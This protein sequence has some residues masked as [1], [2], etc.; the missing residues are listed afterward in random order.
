MKKNLIIYI[1]TISLSILYI[2]LLG[3]T[4]SK[5]LEL[6]VNSDDVVKAKV[7]GILNTDLNEYKLGDD[8]HKQ[9]TI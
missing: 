9:K 6:F 8:I 4:F 1:V 5:D 3:N 7:I 2:V